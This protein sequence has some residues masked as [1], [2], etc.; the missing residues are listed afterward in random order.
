MSFL[1][2]RKEESAGL[3]F[4]A[5]GMAN[6]MGFT[7]SGRVREMCGEDDSILGCAISPGE[8]SCW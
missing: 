3:G 2:G 7:E 1:P 4:V 5:G 8:K 6:Q